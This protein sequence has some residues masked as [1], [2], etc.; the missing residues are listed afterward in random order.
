MPERAAVATVFVFAMLASSLIGCSTARSPESLVVFNQ[1]GGPQ[2][3][4][5]RVDGQVLYKGLLGTVEYAP[6]IV[7]D[8]TL[9]LEKGSHTI[10]AE[11]PVHSFSKCMPVSVEKET[12]TMIVSVDRDRVQ[13]DVHYGVIAFE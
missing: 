5:I 6:A 7:I 1:S 9:W 10:C 13:M 3:I 11:V 8:Q 2:R 4:E 12:V